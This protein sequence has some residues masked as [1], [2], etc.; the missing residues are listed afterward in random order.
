MSTINARN[1]II[2][3]AHAFVIW[4]LCGASVGIGMAVTSEKNA[5]IIHAIFA[6]VISAIVASIYFK[7]FNYTNPLQTAVV[8]VSFVIFMDFFVV[9]LLILGNFEM[10][11][12][13]LGTWIPFALMFISTYATGS[14]V[15]RRVKTAGR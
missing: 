11:A 1:V 6:P 3:L 8:F 5:L 2:L 15:G 10:F 4:A 12:S 13:A 7:W 14:F 9:S